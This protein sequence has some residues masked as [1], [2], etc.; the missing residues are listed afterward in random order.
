MTETTTRKRVKLPEPTK[1]YAVPRPLRLH[2]TKMLP[3]D[4]ARANLRLSHVVHALQRTD[5]D[6]HTVASTTRRYLSLKGE[7]LHAKEIFASLSQTSVLASL[8]AVQRAVNG[9]QTS[10]YRDGDKS[11]HRE[12]SAVDPLPKI[13][14]ARHNNELNKNYFDQQR[15]LKRVQMKLRLQPGHRPSNDF[16]KIVSMALHRRLRNLI[17][18]TASVTKCRSS[19]HNTP[20]SLFRLDSQPKLQVRDINAKLMQRA[21]KRKEHEHKKLLQLGERTQKRK[22]ND[23]ELDEELLIRAEKA[24]EEEQERQ[25]ADAANEATR[26]ALGDAKYLRW[27]TNE[28]KASQPLKH[29]EPQSDMNTPAL[30]PSEQITDHWPGNHGS[31]MPMDII[32]VLK[33]E[34]RLQ[35]I[36]TK[37]VSAELSL[38]SKKKHKSNI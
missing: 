12:L 25:L 19:V 32:C 29:V 2:L 17:S 28:A 11:T 4:T 22:Q 8:K 16:T 1:P 10:I 18:K 30:N 38:S 24:R 33:A 20:S 5:V 7:R 27:F 36:L 13:R 9:S 3:V 14:A 35:H 15:L 6:S 34:G 23:E 37:F 31:I 21:A 26:S